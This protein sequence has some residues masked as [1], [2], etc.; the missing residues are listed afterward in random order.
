MFVN[1][2][3]FVVA[4]TDVIWIAV[5]NQNNANDVTIGD[6]DWSLHKL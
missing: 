1:G 5:L 2:L 4:A 3:V 6:M